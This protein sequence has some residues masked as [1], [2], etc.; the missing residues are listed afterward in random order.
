MM[1]L[2][3]AVFQAAR[4]TALLGDKVYPF[5]R[6]PATKLGGPILIMSEYN[7][8]CTEPLPTA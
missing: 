5:G 4:G 7:S 1:L 8:T 6:A 2:D 3:T